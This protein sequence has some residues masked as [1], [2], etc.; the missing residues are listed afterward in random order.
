MRRGSAAAALNACIE[1]YRRVAGSAE[2]RLAHINDE[3]RA[4]LRKGAPRAAAAAAARPPRESRSCAPLRPPPRRAEC[5]DAEGW[6]QDGLSATAA[7]ASHENPRITVAAIGDRRTALERACR[8][9]ATKPKPAP[10]V[11]PPPAPAP[12]A[13]AAAPSATEAE[14]PAAAAAAAGEADGKAAEGKEAPSPAA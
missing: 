4:K 1:E 2:E 14:K 5:S 13:A 12:A 9:I 11:V 3:E 10:V 6:M 7:L 8:P